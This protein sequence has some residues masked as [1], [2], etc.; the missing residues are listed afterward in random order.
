MEGEDHAEGGRRPEREER[1]EWGKAPGVIIGAGIGIVFGAAF[2][3]PGTGMVIG[4]AIGLAG[5]F[6]VR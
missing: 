4:A 5:G 3:S 1:E 6:V 2:G